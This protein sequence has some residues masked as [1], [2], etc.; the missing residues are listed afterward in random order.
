MAILYLLCGTP[1]SGKSTWIKNHYKEDD[2]II[3]R[4][5]IRFSMVADGE[6]YFSKEKEVYKEFIKQINENL[7]LGVNVYADATHLNKASRAK[8]LKN[9]K[10]KPDSIEIIWIKTPLLECLK[11]NENR[12]GTRS[13]VPKEVIRRMFI[14][15]EAPEFEEGFNKIYIVED[16]K[17][18][19][20]IEKEI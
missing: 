9:I 3:S 13:Y 17:P 6:E 18:I 12:R 15:T 1:G 14:Q 8:L 16:E 11:R 7:K 5:K 4:D 20:I 10:E 19:Q 2:I